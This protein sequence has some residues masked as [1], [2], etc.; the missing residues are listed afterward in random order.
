MPRSLF[1]RLVIHADDDTGLAQLLHA[2]DHVTRT[3]GAPIPERD[4]Y[5]GGSLAPRYGSQLR[6]TAVVVHPARRAACLSNL[7]LEG[8]GLVLGFTGRLMLPC[9]PVALY[10]LGKFLITAVFE[11]LSGCKIDLHGV[12]FPAREARLWGLSWG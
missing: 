5:A 10:P 8:A 12:A 4:A 1:L 2:A 11:N 9:R 3:G 7:P 6:A